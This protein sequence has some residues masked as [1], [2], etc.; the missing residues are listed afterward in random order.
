MCGNVDLCPTVSNVDQPDVDGDGLGDE[1]DPCPLDADN[2]LDG[3]SVCGD[4]DVCPAAADP[5]QSDSDEDGMGD[6]CDPC[7]DEAGTTRD[8]ACTPATGSDGGG[9]PVPEPDAGGAEED[10]PGVEGTT[11]C[12]CRLSAE[13]PATPVGPAALILVLLGLLRRRRRVG[14]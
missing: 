14:A 9:S 7:P 10:S 13:R 11:G 5:A 4:V 2:D 8:R 3:D 12:G 6:A 1:C